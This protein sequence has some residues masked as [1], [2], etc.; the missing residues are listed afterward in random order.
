MGQRRDRYH[1]M[2]A[3]INGAVAMLVTANAPR[4]R[5]GMVQ[6]AARGNYALCKVA[7]AVGR[8]R[9]SASIRAWNL[10]PKSVKL[11]VINRWWLT[12]SKR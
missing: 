3:I 5:C 9:S 10:L 8:K 11:V 2:N 12:G 4:R 6:S 1:A 7:S